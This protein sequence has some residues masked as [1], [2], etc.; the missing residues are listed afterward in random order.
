M[1][2][3]M[4]CVTAMAALLLLPAAGLGALDRDDGD[5]DAQA[6]PGN[7]NSARGGEQE[8]AVEARAS[9]ANWSK[10]RFE[11]R[12]HPSLRAGRFF[13][14]DFHLKYQH[15]FRSFDPEFTAEEAD[16]SNV[17]KFRVGVAGVLFRHFEFEVERELR[18]EA[19]DL[20]DIS[21]R[22]TSQTW[23]DV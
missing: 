4:A 7:Q 11:M 1:R 15:E 19:A 14:M 2:I 20:L 23:R 3:P 12:R 6:E 9:K 5:D 10:P 16:L 13:H 22:T 18:N 17:R 8:A 21:T